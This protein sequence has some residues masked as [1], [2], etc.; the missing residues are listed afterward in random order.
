MTDRAAHAPIAETT[1]LVT[2]RQAVAVP[3]ETD[4]SAMAR[5]LQAGLDRLSAG[6]R[7]AYG[8]ALRRFSAF[9]AATMGLADDD[10]WFT[11]QLVARHGRVVTADI[12]DRF[13][14]E[15]CAG[16]ASATIAQRQAAIRWAFA[17]LYEAGVIDWVVKVRSPKIVSY[18]DTAG[19]GLDAIRALLA[20]ADAA[21]GLRGLREAA[22]LRALFVLGLRRGEVTTLRVADWD[23]ALGRLGVIGKGHTD[24][25][26][27][28]VAADLATRIDAYLAARDDAAPTATLFTTHGPRSAGRPLTGDAIRRSLIRLSRA[29]GLTKA[30]RPHGLRHAAITQALDLFGGDVRRVARFSRHAKV[31]TVLTYDDRRR[32]MAGEVS[33]GLEGLLTPIV[34]AADSTTEDA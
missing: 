18:R 25:Q 31:E 9:A 29:A 16:R 21:P 27:L 11:L 23:P 32:D 28:S 12:I 13:A 1:E 33:E 3:H 19:P 22:L 4:A 5:R 34:Q 6:T 20:A 26:F 8:F 30:V 17:L 7:R 14:T 10:W 2:Q 24:R 15:A